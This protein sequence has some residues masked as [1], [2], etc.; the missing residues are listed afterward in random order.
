MVR[1]TEREPAGAESPAEPTTGTRRFRRV[2]PMPTATLTDRDAFLSAVRA[3]GLLTPA[4]RLKADAAT[5]TGGAADAARAFVAAGLLTR[6]QA[7]RLLAGRTDGFHLGPYVIL[8]QV[9]RGAMSRVYKAR[10]R[11]MNRAVAVKVLAAELTRT[12]AARQVLQ[13]EVRTA[14]KLSH[15]NIVTAYDANELHDRFYLVLEF[16]D[17]PNLDAL[18]RQNGPLPVEEACAFVRQVAH[19]LA[20]AHDLGMVH[21]GLKPG[22]LLVARAAGVVKIAD[23]GISRLAPGS[24]DYRAP[25]LFHSPH[26]ADARTD[27]YAL[28]CVFHFLLTGRPPS[29]ADGAPR[30][31]GVRPEVAAIIA[32]LLAKHPGGRFASAGELLAHLDAACAP[33]AT[34]RIDFDIPPAGPYAPDSG[35]LT[36]RHAEPSPWAQLTAATAADTTPTDTPP[37]P[38]HKALRLKPARRNPASLW[39]TLGGAALLC[40]AG[41]AAVVRLLA[42]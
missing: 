26:A 28:G 18:V 25:E 31:G 39:P 13:D 42:K 8:D 35:Y 41:I 23:F 37:P 38:P 20:H 9:G 5:A 17:G 7:D 34:G 2:A 27:L 12:A 11:A 22:N 16:V 30:L 1:T 19:G 4:Q 29:R 14:G 40:V 3:A 36:G 21:G 15:P 10:H 6:F 24:P 32:R 33:A